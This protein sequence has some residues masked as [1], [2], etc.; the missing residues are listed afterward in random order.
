[1]RKSVWMRSPRLSLRGTRRQTRKRMLLKSPSLRVIQSRVRTSQTWVTN[2]RG[3]NLRRLFCQ[4]TNPKSY[5]TNPMLPTPRMMKA[6]MPEERVKKL[7]APAGIASRRKA[8][9]LITAGRVSVNGATVTELGS[10]ADLSK[11]KV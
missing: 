6:K 11:D 3:K 1:M 4:R 7:L 8:E 10:K 5:R 2:K 9:E